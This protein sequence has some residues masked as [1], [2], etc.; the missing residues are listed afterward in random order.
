MHCKGLKLRKH[1]GV[2]LQAFLNP[3][4]AFHSKGRCWEPPMETGAQAAKYRL[5]LQVNTNGVAALPFAGPSADI[6]LG[7]ASTHVPPCWL[8]Q[9]FCSDTHLAFV[10]QNLCICKH[11]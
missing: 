10:T 8:R 4:I 11:T 1:G 7:S 3:Y 9:A 2:L 5:L 6:L